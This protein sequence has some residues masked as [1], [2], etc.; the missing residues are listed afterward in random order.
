MRS[1]AAFIALALAL[2]GCALFKPPP[3][4]IVPPAAKT[5]GC[6]HIPKPL[7]ADKPPKPPASD[8]PQILQ[9]G[10]W[11]W[12]GLNYEWLPQHWVILQSTKKPVW[13]AG[14]WRLDTG[15]CVWVPAHWSVPPVQIKQ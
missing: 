15:A 2:P 7:P 6:P 9:P 5:A 12:G 14:N 1:R 10:A 11:T 8:F 3:K 13:N 4:L